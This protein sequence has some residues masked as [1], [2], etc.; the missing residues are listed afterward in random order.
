MQLSN[1]LTAILVEHHVMCEK[2][3]SCFVRDYRIAEVQQLLIRLPQYWQNT[4]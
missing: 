2:L 1:T 4:M 3:V